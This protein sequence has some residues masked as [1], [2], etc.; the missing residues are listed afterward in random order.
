MKKISLFLISLFISTNLYANE[1]NKSQNQHDNHN[2]Y[3]GNH[4]HDE[5]I[6]N[7]TNIN[8]M[9]DQDIKNMHKN[10]SQE[11][12]KEMHKNMLNH[13]MKHMNHK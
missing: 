10:M 12:M 8:G 13:N 2:N 9:T 4:M 7:H 1:S 11:D 5:K 6:T 3:M